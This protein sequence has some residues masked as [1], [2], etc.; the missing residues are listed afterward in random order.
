MLTNIG[1]LSIERIHSMLK[2]F[3]VTGPTGSQCTLEDVKKFLESKV[4][5]GELLLSG[6]LYRLVKSE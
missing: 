4:K 3:A 1:A 5:S 2:M 6:G